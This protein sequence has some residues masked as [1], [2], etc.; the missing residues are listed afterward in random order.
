MFLVKI[1]IF[2]FVMLLFLFVILFLYI[3]F[4]KGDYYSICSK[5]PFIDKE[6]RKNDE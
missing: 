5:L 1:K 6:L 4:K 3:L 2:L